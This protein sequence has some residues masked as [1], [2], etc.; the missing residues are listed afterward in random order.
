M[1]YLEKYTPI[2][3]TY[4]SVTILVNT[5]TWQYIKLYL[6]NR[7]LCQGK[8]L[9]TANTH[10]TILK[11]PYFKWFKSDLEVHLYIQYPVLDFPC[12]FE[13][14]L[15][16]T[17]QYLNKQPERN[18]FSFY[19]FKNKQ[20]KAVAFIHFI[21]IPDEPVTS[22]S[23]VPFGGI[24]CTENCSTQEL[25]FLL[26][27]VESWI[28]K[29]N[30]ACIFIKTAPLCYP[31]GAKEALA[32]AY[33]AAGYKPINMYVNYHINVA[34]AP[35]YQTIVRSERRRLLKCRNA[36]FQANICTEPNVQIIY[37]FIRDSRDQKNYFL[38]ITREQMEL[39]LSDFP[40]QYL[41]FEVTDKGKIIALSLAVRVH[42][43]VLYNFLPADLA[44][45][46]EYSPM[47][48]LNEAMYEYCQNEGIS[49]LDLGISLDHHGVEKSGLI[50]FKQNLGGK[51][52][53]K[54][55]YGKSK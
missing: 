48:L 41:V 28:S 53:L 16:H 31:S 15:Y 13:P 37:N 52:S 25:Q 54:I 32:C 4:L 20:K 34:K 40:H 7:T 35:F 11:T 3:P 18:Y 29:Q 24:Q 36:G 14:F 43:Q 51:Q 39:L 12:H 22:L 17:A 49:I 10:I 5:E 2:F 38:P 19:L 42:T 27:S 47:V 26:T 46:H 21:K 8:N 33:H 55:T 9:L 50:R 44:D 1:K 23:F 45:Y 30:E 6:L